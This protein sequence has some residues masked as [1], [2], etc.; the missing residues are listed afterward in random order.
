MK[1]K[2]H[3]QRK[4]KV[5]ARKSS[6]KTVKNNPRISSTWNKGYSFESMA[7]TLVNDRKDILVM[8]D[9]RKGTILKDKTIMGLMPRQVLDTCISEVKTKMEELGDDY[10]DYI[11][12]LAFHNLKKLDKDPSL[13]VPLAINLAIWLIL[14]GV[15]DDYTHSHILISEGDGVELTWIDEEGLLDGVFKHMKKTQVNYCEGVIE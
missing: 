4:K 15:E 14:Y 11:S 7:E 8:L 10:A 5:Q 2:K 13:V 9:D 12:T 6:F 3:N 1:T